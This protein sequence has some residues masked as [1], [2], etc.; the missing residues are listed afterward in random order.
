V[1][2]T[3]QKI[4]FEQYL[5]HDDRTDQRYELVRGELILM[6]P[7]IFKH[8]FIAKFL[9][10]IFDAEIARLGLP[11]IALK[12]SGQRT[13]VDSSRLPDLCIVPLAEAEA[14]HYSPAVF[15]LPALLVAEIVSPSS[16]KDDYEDKLKE[17]QAI[18]VAE[19]WI[20]DPVSKDPRVTIYSL[21][22]GTYAN[23]VFRGSE[24]IISA[25]FPELVITASQ[26]MAAKL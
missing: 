1:V 26:I 19:Y 8:I 11:W 14:R 7:P 23:Q 16:V 6:T 20:V 22:N 3:Q 25:V 24:Q 4:T 10:R 18:G 21:E 12:G 9:E 17:Y 5:C 13:D 2:K 15:Q